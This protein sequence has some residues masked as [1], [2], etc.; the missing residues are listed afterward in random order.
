M[1]INEALKLLGQ[2]QVYYP[3]L[4]KKI[5]IEE[6]IFLTYLGYWSN[7]NNE[8]FRTNNEICD[9]TALSASQVKRVKALFNKKGWITKQVKGIERVT[10]YTINWDKINDDIKEQEIDNGSETTHSN[11]SKRPI[12]TGQNKP[13]QRSET[14]H[15]NGLKQPIDNIYNNI[16]NNR[17]NNI[18]KGFEKVIE[19]WLNYKQKRRETYKNEQQIQIMINRLIKISNNSPDIANEII[20]QSIA[21]NYAGFFELKGSKNA[22]RRNNK[23]T[24]GYE[25][26]A[27][28]YDDAEAF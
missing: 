27:A 10:F 19:K 22:N 5:G 12:A 11:G 13:L 20:E 9:D 6:A 15:S 8:L 26:Q 16:Y 2:G 3:K 25:P 24:V 1:K 7:E 28:H 23:A 4:A 21:N 14:T 18:P 17:N